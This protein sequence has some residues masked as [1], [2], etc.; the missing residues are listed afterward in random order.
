MIFERRHG[1]SNVMAKALESDREDR[2][3]WA[4]AS[5]DLLVLDEEGESDCS[6]NYGNHVDHLHGEKASMKRS[7][8]IQRWHQHQHINSQPDEL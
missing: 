3:S 4:W 6:A 2:V 5:K 7:L 8:L 1:D